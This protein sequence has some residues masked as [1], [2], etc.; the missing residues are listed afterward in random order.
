[1][2]QNFSKAMMPDH[3][4]S[5]QVGVLAERGQEQLSLFKWD[6]T[7]ALADGLANAFKKKTGTLHDAAAQHNGV[8][9]K[10]IDQVREAKPQIEGFALYSGK[11]HLI[12]FHRQL[13]DSLGGDAPAMRVV[14]RRGAF[15]PG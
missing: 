5:N 14:R 7:A 10:Q 8:R 4:C 9:S 6:E 12:A 15:E 2:L 13:A 11:S 3:R 1:M